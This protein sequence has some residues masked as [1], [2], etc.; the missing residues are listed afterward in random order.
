MM[1]FSSNVR[2]VNSY[3]IL[4]LFYTKTAYYHHYGDICPN[5]NSILPFN[6]LNITKY[7]VYN[8]PFFIDIKITIVESH[9]LIG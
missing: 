6:K 7:Y 1:V 9:Q 8:I 4:Q 3:S 5:L 2:T